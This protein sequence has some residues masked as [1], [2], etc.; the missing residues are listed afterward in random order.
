MQP[1]SGVETFA[2]P[3]AESGPRAFSR[4]EPLL[5]SGLSAFPAVR[6]CALAAHTPLRESLR[7]FPRCESAF[8]VSRTRSSFP[9]RRTAPRRKPAAGIPSILVHVLLQA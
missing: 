2:G 3:G 8:L 4:Q 5:F 1:F 7:A 6:D 9:S